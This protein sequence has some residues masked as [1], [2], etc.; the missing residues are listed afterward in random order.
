MGIG[1]EHNAE[2]VGS[3]HM[4]TKE[5][6]NKKLSIRIFGPVCCLN[7]IIFTKISSET[8]NIYKWLF[9]FHSNVTGRERQN[10]LVNGRMKHSWTFLGAGKPNVWVGTGLWWGIYASP[11]LCF[12]LWFLLSADLVVLKIEHIIPPSNLSLQRD[13]ANPRYILINSDT[14]SQKNLLFVFFFAL[15]DRHGQAW[16]YGK[17]QSRSGVQDPP[18]WWFFHRRAHNYT[19]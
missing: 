19:F 1:P 18:L 13:Q 4:K 17:Q 5:N 9:S 7:K 12:W 11:T 16:F 3:N 10:G 15:A 2:S 6:Y 14:N 8:T